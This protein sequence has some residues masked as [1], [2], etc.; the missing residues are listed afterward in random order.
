MQAFHVTEGCILH[1]CLDAGGVVR[2]AVQV[3]GT[4]I[5]ALH[6][7]HDQIQYIRC[8][9]TNAGEVLRVYGGVLCGT[10]VLVLYFRFS[11]QN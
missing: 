2:T 1:L 6:Y 11:D 10:G 8:R 9:S 5:S 4:S 7:R 3:P